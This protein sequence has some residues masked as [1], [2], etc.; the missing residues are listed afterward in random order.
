MRE[1]TLKEQK[2]TIK[3]FVTG[4]KIVAETFEMMKSAYSEEYLFRKAV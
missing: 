2:P 1:L 3:F 4:N